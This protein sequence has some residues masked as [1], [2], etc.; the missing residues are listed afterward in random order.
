MDFSTSNSYES[1]RIFLGREKSVLFVKA[2]RRGRA[3]RRPCWEGSQ[4]R[5]K[6]RPLRRPPMMVG[7]P[8]LNPLG[9]L[10]LNPV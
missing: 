9:T 5:R 3:L 10:P 8:S 1:S 2:I 6:A 7:A 4:G